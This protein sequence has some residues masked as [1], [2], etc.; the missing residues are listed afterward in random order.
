MTVGT[1]TT[2]TSYDVPFS[3][4]PIKT[5][6]FRP[7]KIPHLELEEEEEEEEEEESDIQFET[8][9]QDS[10]FNPGDSSISH[11]SEMSLVIHIYKFNMLLRSLI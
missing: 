5:P 10:T 3:S 2:S 4:T 9:P 6:C 1:I 7:P 11:E 8:E